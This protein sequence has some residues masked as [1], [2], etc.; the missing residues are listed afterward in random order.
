MECQGKTSLGP[1]QTFPDATSQRPDSL[2]IDWKLLESSGGII[3]M[4]EF[5]HGSLCDL[6]DWMVAVWGNR[7]LLCGHRS[8]QKMN[9]SFCLEHHSLE[10]MRWSPPNFSQ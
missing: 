8:L 6:G 2:E 7:M 9:L 1:L 5:S 3:W 4:R 10:T